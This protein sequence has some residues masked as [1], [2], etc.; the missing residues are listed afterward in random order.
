MLASPAAWD[1]RFTVCARNTLCFVQWQ[2]GSS[3]A[4][5]ADFASA[6]SLCPWH[7]RQQLHLYPRGD[8]RLHR[9]NRLRYLCALV[10]FWD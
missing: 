6:E 3:G 8:P 2:H 5:G 4:W 9:L 10:S 7:G 1:I